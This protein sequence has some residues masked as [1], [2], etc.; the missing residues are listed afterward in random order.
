MKPIKVF[1]PFR[2]KTLAMPP[3]CSGFK[4]EKQTFQQVYVNFIKMFGSNIGK[5]CFFAS[6]IKL[7]NKFSKSES[8]RHE[9]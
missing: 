1:V 9:I 7:E 2:L 4:R 5:L 3:N 6:N 8:M